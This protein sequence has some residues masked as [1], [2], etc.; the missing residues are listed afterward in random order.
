VQTSLLLS[1]LVLIL[2][3]G[4]CSPCAPW[5]STAFAQ[6]ATRPAPPD[7][8]KLDQLRKDGQGV[9]GKKP[10]SG[11]QPAAGEGVWSIV[12]IACRGEGAEQRAEQAAEK[13]RA[14]GRLP[15]V[16]VEQR[17]E[18]FVVAYG[19]YASP[20]DRAKKDLQRVRDTSVNGE[21]P[22]A[23][24]AL[25]PPAFSGLTGSFP[26]YELLAAKQR[27]G[28]RALYTLQVAVYERSDGKEPSADDF[29]MIRA[30]A[31]KAAVQMRRE[32]EEAYYFHG[33][34]R[35]MVTIGL[36]DETEYD[37]KAPGK[38]KQSKRLLDLRKAHP[39]NLVNGQGMRVKIKGQKGEGDISPSFLVN[40]PDK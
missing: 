11:D 13:V 37:T 34:R 3:P 30:A 33:P 16:Y 12:I 39:Y 29:K 10:N 8:K 27:A 9:F 5:G 21:T 15:D 18:A 28:K 24:A 19:R 36:F 40:V 38:P 32:G 2:V 6:P 14:E 35:S 31:E 22:F 17:G 4:L 1:R 20:D 25:S 26:E 7:Q 23:S